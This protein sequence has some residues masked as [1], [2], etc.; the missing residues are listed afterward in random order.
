LHD[1]LPFLPNPFAVWTNAL[2]V[3]VTIVIIGKGA[4]WVVEAAARIAQRLGISELVIGLTVVSLGTSAPEFAVTLLAAFQ[5]EGNISVGN[6]VG[7]N[8]F[9]LGFILG[10]CA[11]VR[12]IPTSRTLVLRDGAVLVGT[13]VALLLMLGWD[14][15]LN[16][17]DGAILF[18]GLVIYL[19]YLFMN[20]KVMPGSEDE[21]KELMAD[22]EAKL[23]MVREGFFLIL[24]LASIVLGSHLLVEAATE[25]AEAYKVPSWVIAVTV[26]AAGTSAPEFATSLMGVIKGRYGISAGN[27]IGSDIF[28]LL[29]VLGLAGLV[30]PVSVHPMARVSL[31]ALIGMVALVVFFMR[32]GWRVSRWEGGFL[33]ALAL[34]RW[35]FDFMSQG[36]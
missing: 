30:Q 35:I 17:Y 11:L 14:L 33:V 34:A 5:G 4:S 13:T 32:T 2:I 7:S 16:R 25:I 29:G 24:G 21:L 8:I 23:S 15:K 36:S 22:D 26:V 12:A 6:I 27:L 18:T 3:L 1:L 28:N 10:G 20:R 9:N 19:G 31:A